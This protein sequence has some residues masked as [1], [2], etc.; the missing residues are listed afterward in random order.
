MEGENRHGRNKTWKW[1][2]SGTFIILAFGRVSDSP[3]DR[4][5]P[6]SLISKEPGAEF[7]FPYSN[8]KTVLGG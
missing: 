3:V 7:A 4:F 8:G 2:F 5:W 1:I 6:D